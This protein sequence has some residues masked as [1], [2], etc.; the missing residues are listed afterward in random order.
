MSS[1]EEIANSVS[2]AETRVLKV[3]WEQAP[4]TADHIIQRLERDGPAHPRTVKTL[5]N[6]LTKKH[7]V[8]FHEKDR[9][10]HYYPLIEEA[11]FF[12]LKSTSFLNK[13]FSGRLSPMISCFSRPGELDPDDLAELKRLLNQLEGN[14][15]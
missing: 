8:G 6:R 13:Y 5:L 9:R 12:R 3:L 1:Q 7:A 2:E 4:L 14:D 15:E 11:E 10:Y